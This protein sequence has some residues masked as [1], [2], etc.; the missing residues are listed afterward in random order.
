MAAAALVREHGWLPGSVGAQLVAMRHEAE[1]GVARTYVFGSEL[2]EQHHGELLAGMRIPR[3]LEGFLA[4][5]AP[6]LTPSTS[7]SREQP[8]LQGSD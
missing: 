1:E 8:S 6:L 4:L 5:E 7:V 3:Q 2:L